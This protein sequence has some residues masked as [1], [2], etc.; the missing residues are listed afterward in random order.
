MGAINAEYSKLADVPN[1]ERLR[2]YDYG[3]GLGTTARADLVVSGHP[4]LSALYRFAWINVKN[5]STFNYG[6]FGGDADHYIQ[7]GGLR[8]LIP[9]KGSVG[10]GGDAFLFLRNSDYTFTD[11]ATGRQVFQHISQRNP[12]VRVYVALH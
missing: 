12:Q 9:I 3:P 8:L 7:G 11:S 6:T 5:G 10:V 2:E 1:R 4:V